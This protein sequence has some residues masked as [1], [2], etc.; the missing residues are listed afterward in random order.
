MKAGYDRRKPCASAGFAS[1]SVKAPTINATLKHTLSA[2]TAVLTT[3]P[4]PRRAP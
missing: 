2:H 1:F 4:S 3:F